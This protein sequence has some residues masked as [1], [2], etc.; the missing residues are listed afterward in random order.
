MGGIGERIY[1]GAVLRTLG[2]SRSQLRRAILSEFALMGGV[3]GFLA[4][5]AAIIVG[6]LLATRVFEIDYNPR[7]WLPLAGLLAGAVTIAITGILGSRQVLKTPPAVI[8]RK[9]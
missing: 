6:W 2:G 5:V 8:L 3:A 1:E 9:A 7:F 4:A